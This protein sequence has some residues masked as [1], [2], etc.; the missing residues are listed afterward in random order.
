MNQSRINSKHLIS[1]GDVS[2]NGRVRFELKQGAEMNQASRIM[3]AGAPNSGNWKTLITCMRGEFR[4]IER[5]E[6]YAGE[7]D[8]GSV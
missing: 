6:R 8:D 4:A 2:R 5:D 1:R 7:N 3:K